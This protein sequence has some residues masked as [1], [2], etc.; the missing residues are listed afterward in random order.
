MSFTLSMFDAAVLLI[1]IV[2]VYFTLFSLCVGSQFQ[3]MH[4]VGKFWMVGYMSKANIQ[5]NDPTLW[6]ANQLKNGYK[7]ILSHQRCKSNVTKYIFVVVW[8]G[9]LLTGAWMMVFFLSFFG[10]R[11]E[12]KWNEIMAVYIDKVET[13]RTGNMLKWMCSR[14]GEKEARKKNIEIY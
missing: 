14:G 5:L 10:V 7:M 3:L 11:T 12:A 2:V 6:P 9:V 1:V 13:Q 4:F 8:C